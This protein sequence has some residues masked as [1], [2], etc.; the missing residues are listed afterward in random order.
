MMYKEGKEVK[1]PI[2]LLYWVTGI[3]SSDLLQK[4]QPLGFKGLILTSIF[5]HFS[6]GSTF[7]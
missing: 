4:H 5:F 2:I 1:I 6:I 7:V 3:L